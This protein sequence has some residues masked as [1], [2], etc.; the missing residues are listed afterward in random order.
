MFFDSV[1]PYPSHRAQTGVTPENILEFGAHLAA[2]THPPLAEI[3]QYWDSLRAGRMMPLRSEVEPREMSSFLDCCFILDQRAAGDIRFRLAGMR[4]N[5]LM[6]MELR[7]MHI[8]SMIEPEGRAKFSATLEKMFAT[9][10]IQ[11]FDLTSRAPNTTTVT[12][13]LLVLPLKGNKGHVDR[14]MGC[15]VTTGIIGIPPRRFAV[16]RV[17]RTSL[18]TGA[19]VSQEERGP[20]AAE[21]ATGAPAGFAEERAPFAFTPASERRDDTPTGVPYLRVVK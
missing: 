18:M 12:G 16:E 21:I 15:M 9:P 8:R 19:R 13:K 10:E 14:A 11:E 5:D 2:M 3:R 4:L 7:G 1:P 6:G 17:L 20:V